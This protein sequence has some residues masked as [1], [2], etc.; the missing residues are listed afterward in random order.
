MHGV[1][2]RDESKS[3]CAAGSSILKRRGYEQH[4]LC[5][6]VSCMRAM[7]HRCDG[8][9]QVE[10]PGFLAYRTLW[11]TIAACSASQH[12]LSRVLRTSPWPQSHAWDPV[13]Q[14]H[15]ALHV[16]V[17]CPLASLQWTCHSR[18]SQCRC[19]TGDGGMPRPSAGTFSKVGSLLG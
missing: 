16:C 1:Q 4:M 3:I 7:L 14:S 18:L 2:D 19:A 12:A 15:M 11:T 5:A 10:P 9:L 8:P 13:H 17:A 6:G